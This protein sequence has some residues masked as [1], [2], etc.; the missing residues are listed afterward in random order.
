MR[1]LHVQLLGHVG[2]HEGLADGL[3]AGDPERAVAVSIF[4]VGGLHE[5]LARDLLHGAQHRLVADPAP[6]QAELKHHLF[7]RIW[8]YGHVTPEAA[9]SKRGSRRSDPPCLMPCGSEA[10]R[11]ISL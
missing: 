5:R 3:A 7:R 8:R 11:K 10:L 1:L 6:P 9:F 2:N 4:T